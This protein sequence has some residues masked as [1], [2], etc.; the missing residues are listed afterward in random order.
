MS[1]SWHDLLNAIEIIKKINST[2]RTYYIECVIYNTTPPHPHLSAVRR[3][4]LK[5]CLEEKRLP[6]R[7]RGEKDNLL[8]LTGFARVTIRRGHIHILSNADG[9]L[10]DAEFR[11]KFQWH[12]I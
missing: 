3:F 9:A 7:S 10:S 2:K 5:V 6:S 11:S 12:S 4:H 8:L 1:F